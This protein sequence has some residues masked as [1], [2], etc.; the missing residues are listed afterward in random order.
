MSYEFFNEIIARI[1]EM[2]RTLNQL[3]DAVKAKI[4]EC[5]SLKDSDTIDRRK[6]EVA[7]LHNPQHNQ[8]GAA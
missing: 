3:R 5:M 8:R 4:Q 2:Q 1:E 7:S 6:T